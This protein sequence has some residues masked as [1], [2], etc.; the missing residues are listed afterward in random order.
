LVVK[1]VVF[2][3]WL[4]S[5]LPEFISSPDNIHFLGFGHGS[6]LEAPSPLLGFGAEGKNARPEGSDATL[7]H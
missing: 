4:A 6:L 1:F 3:R 2:A 7:K 5:S